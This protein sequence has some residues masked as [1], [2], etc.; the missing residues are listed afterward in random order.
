MAKTV[1]LTDMSLNMLSEGMFGRVIEAE[2]MRITADLEQRG[3]DGKARK[4]VIQIDAKYD[5]ALKRYVLTP[6]CQAKLP[7]QQ[8]YPTQANMGYDGVKKGY[9]FNFNPDS[10]VPDQG[11]IDETIDK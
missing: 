2:M 10:V 8:A 9:V 11:T 3:S 1:D 6:T 5:N 4:L 7:P